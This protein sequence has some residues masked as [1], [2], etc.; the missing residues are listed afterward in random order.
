MATHAQL[1]TI[2]PV[3]DLRTT[4]IPQLTLHA[5]AIA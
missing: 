5:V 4:T 2:V 1:G 3:E